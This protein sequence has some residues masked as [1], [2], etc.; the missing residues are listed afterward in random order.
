MVVPLYVGITDLNRTPVKT[1]VDSLL[2][3]I[4][5]YLMSHADITLQNANTLVKVTFLSMDHVKALRTRR[6]L[7]R[8]FAGFNKRAFDNC[9]KL[10]G[11]KGGL[12]NR[13]NFTIP[14]GFYSDENAFEKICLICLICVGKIWALGNDSSRPSHDQ[15]YYKRLYK[16][17]KQIYCRCKTCKTESSLYRH[18]ISGGRKLKA[19]VTT[20]MQNH[21]LAMNAAPFS[22][23]ELSRVILAENVCIKI[24]N[25]NLQRVIVSYPKNTRLTMH[26]IYAI[27]TTVP[28]AH[29]HLDLAIHPNTLFKKNNVLCVFCDKLMNRDN[30]YRSALPISLSFRRLISSFF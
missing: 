6:P 18:Q 27:E 1:P 28:N 3:V 4:G 30:L 12:S 24:I 19:E 15:N 9:K 25:A 8:K 7:K 11:R 26:I 20:F 16:S 2:Y 17:F 10:L 13:V 14:R 29:S 5:N 22:I 23:S 21:K